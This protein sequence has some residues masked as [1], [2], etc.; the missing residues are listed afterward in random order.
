M[1]K[2]INLLDTKHFLICALKT[3]NTVTIIA[4]LLLQK[5]P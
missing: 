4:Q 1:K 3:F 5:S 2:S